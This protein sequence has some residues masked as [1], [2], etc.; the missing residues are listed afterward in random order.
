MDSR[1]DN[2]SQLPTISIVVGVVLKVKNETNEMT[3]TIESEI[4]I[5]TSNHDFLISE[6]N[7]FM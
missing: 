6:K 7:D 4:K 3:K 2:P 1:P 5:L